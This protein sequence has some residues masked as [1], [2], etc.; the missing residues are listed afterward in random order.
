MEVVCEKYKVKH[1]RSSPYHPQSNGLIERTNQTVAAKIAKLAMK[2][3]SNWDEYVYDA[4]YGYNIAPQKLLGVSPYEALY[5]R[6]PTIT[7][8]ESQETTNLKTLHEEIRNRIAENKRKITEKQA[9]LPQPDDLEVGDIVLYR[10]RNRTKGQ[11]WWL[12]PYCISKKGTKGAYYFTTLEG[13]K[14]YQSHRNDLR[15]FKGGESFEDLICARIEDDAE[16]GRGVVSAH[17]LVYV[18]E[19]WQAGPPANRECKIPRKEVSSQIRHSIR[20]D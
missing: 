12:G 15:V 10:N 19:P 11:P 18:E 2:N 4:V 17:N 13:T 6:T 5:G 16:I 20:T 9:T 14:E 1:Q 3:Q 8:Q 7:G